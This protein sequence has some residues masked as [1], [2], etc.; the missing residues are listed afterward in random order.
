[1]IE[2][3]RDSARAVSLGL[4][5]NTIQSGKLISSSNTRIFFPKPAEQT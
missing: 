5:A 1:V 4:N 2:E 3:L